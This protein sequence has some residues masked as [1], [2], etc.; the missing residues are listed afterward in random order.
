MLNSLASIG[1]LNEYS[2]TKLDHYDSLKPTNEDSPI[3]QPPIL[4]T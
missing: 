1:N 4:R 2:P 3:K